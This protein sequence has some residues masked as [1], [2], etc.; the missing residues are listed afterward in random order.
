[1]ENQNTTEENSHSHND[2]HKKEEMTSSS[3]TSSNVSGSDHR[4]FMNDF[5]DPLAETPRKSKLLG[6]VVFLVVVALALQFTGFWNWLNNSL[7]VDTSLKND[8]E[9]VI[10]ND[11]E[12]DN[13]DNVSIDTNDATSTMKDTSVSDLV[14]VP[15]K[16]ML[17]ILLTSG[18]RNGAALT[19]GI[20]TVEINKLY[21]HNPFKDSWVLVYEGVRPLDLGV[22]VSTPH[23]LMSTSISALAYDAVRLEYTDLTKSESEN[24][25][26]AEF[27]TGITVV[28][29]KKNVM[30][31]WFN[32]ADPAHLELELFTSVK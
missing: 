20:P 21:L 1:M 31:V 12:E 25:V 11:L 8:V 15:G 3:S 18:V 5:V 24:N 19:S 7:S 14:V 23:E 13:S 4:D 22:L 9:E 16:G 26:T 10:G 30:N 2:A 28:E 32:L 17:S 27:P 29:E 6:M